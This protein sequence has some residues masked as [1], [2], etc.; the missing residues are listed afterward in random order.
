L[1]VTLLEATWYESTVAAIEV[2][3]VTNAIAVAAIESAVAAMRKEDYRSPT[4]LLS[5]AEYR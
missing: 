1:R 5:K 3:V 2:A 4:E